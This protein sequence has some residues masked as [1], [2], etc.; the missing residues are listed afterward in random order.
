MLMAALS[1]VLSY[2]HSQ[3]TTCIHDCKKTILDQVFHKLDA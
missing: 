1:D 2:M 3:L